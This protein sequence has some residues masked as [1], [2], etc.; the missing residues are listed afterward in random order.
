MNR[1]HFLSLTATAA[2]ASLAGPSRAEAIPGKT[3]ILIYL[4]GGNDAYNTLV[5]YTDPRYYQSRPN[6]ALKSEQ[7]IHLSTTQGW[8][9]AM[10]ALL[11]A[12]E[13]RQCALIQGIGQQDVTNQHYRDLETQFT[14]ADP[15]EYRHDGW[16]TRAL[17]ANP[18]L[19]G[20][21]LDAIAFGQL[22]IRESDPMGPFRGQRARVVNITHPSE[23]L[24]AQRIATTQH[25]ATATAQA[26]AKNYRQERAISLNTR[27]PA[28]AFGDALRASV[29]LVAAGIAPPVIHITLNADDGDHHHAFDTHWQQLDYHGAALTRLA[30]WLSALRQ[31]MI[32]IWHWDQSLVAS[33]DEFGRSP[34]E[35]EQRGTHHGWASTHLVMGGQVKGGFY[36]EALPIVKVFAIGGPKPVID[37]RALYTTLIENWWG[38]SANGVFARRF[39]PLPILSA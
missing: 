31:G 37:T 6:I 22:D 8:H 15:D 17:E 30:T 5:P 28:D 14:G 29:E 9:P 34:K 2:L 32:E 16:L 13:A 21:T 3:L 7:L 10:Q 24:A 35:N 33:Y 23:W 36:G 1:R 25:L 38:G 27:F 19:A 20:K 39:K 4:E 18:S 26:A 11:P 12:W